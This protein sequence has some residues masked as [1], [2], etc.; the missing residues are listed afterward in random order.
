MQSNLLL[1]SFPGSLGPR[2]VAPDMVLSMGQIELFEI[3]TELSC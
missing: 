2:E 3:Q 1:L